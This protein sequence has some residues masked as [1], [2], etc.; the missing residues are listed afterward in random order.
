MFR[1]LYKY[2]YSLIYR[3]PIY[4]GINLSLTLF[5]LVKR[6]HI[7]INVRTS[8]DLAYINNLIK[9]YF[10][11]EGTKYILNIYVICIVRVNE[12]RT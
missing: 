3:V 8:V 10:T 1:I 7:K 12:A 2:T 4:V 6:F 11:Y 5:V 9:K